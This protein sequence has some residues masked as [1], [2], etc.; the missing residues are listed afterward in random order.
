[1]AIK[2]VKL[3]QPSSASFGGTDGIELPKGTTAQRPAAVNGLMRQ[4]ET[5]GDIEVAFNNTWVTY[6]KA[7]SFNAEQTGNFVAGANTSTPVDTR[8]G[9]VDITLPVNPSIS[10]EVILF[11]SQRV[12][13][14]NAVQLLRNGE[15]ID[16]VATN[17]TLSLKGAMARLVFIG[18]T[19]GWLLDLPQEDGVAVQPSASDYPLTMTPNEDY[20]APL[21]RSGTPVFVFPENPSVGNTISVLSSDGIDFIGGAVIFKQA[22]SGEIIESIDADWV[23]KQPTLFMEW[24]YTGPTRGWNISSTATNILAVYNSTNNYNLNTLVIEGRYPLNGNL[25]AFTGVPLAAQHGS[26]FKGVMDVSEV[27]GIVFQELKV[28]ANVDAGDNTKVF[29]RNGKPNGNGTAS[30]VSDWVEVKTVEAGGRSVQ[31]SRPNMFDGFTE[32]NYSFVNPTAGTPDHQ[33]GDDYY[34]T[35]ISGNTGNP[36]AKANSSIREITAVNL[37]T[38]TTWVTTT[39]TE[40]TIR[41]WRNVIGNHSVVIEAG[42][43]LDVVVN[44]PVTNLMVLSDANQAIDLTIGSSYGDLVSSHPGDI[45]NIDNVRATTGTTSIVTD[46]N[47]YDENDN[48]LGTGPLT[49]TGQGTV[50]LAVV[51]KSGLFVLQIFS[52]VKS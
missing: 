36:D 33:V 7:G 19:T 28:T 38:S 10:D 25:S 50:K 8:A 47:V 52:S 45:I 18:G 2:E 37:R 1:M 13:D 48:N 39:K 23:C 15:L 40:N 22:A 21:A 41:G 17:K 30:W 6:K 49:M 26:I 5:T 44:A 9:I 29:L 42:N 46:V 16:G 4:N 51:E 27:D 43:D 20:V 12:W 34:V 35:I 32:G 11:D 3:V 24:A 14:K 31:T